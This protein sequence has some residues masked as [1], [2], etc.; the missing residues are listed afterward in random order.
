MLKREYELVT[1]RNG[2]LDMKANRGNYE[3]F[4]ALENH[5]VFIPVEC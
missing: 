2:I 5:K 4:M 1:D 3:R